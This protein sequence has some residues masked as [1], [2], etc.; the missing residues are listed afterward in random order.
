MNSRPDR[1]TPSV[2]IASLVAV[3]AR[4][5]RRLIIIGGV[6][7]L[8]LVVGVVW[9]VRSRA[10]TTV[11][12]PVQTVEVT[13]GAIAALLSTSGSASAA[14]Q[15][16]LTFNAS[17]STTV[18]GV[19]A[20]VDVKVGDRVTQGQ[21]L[22]TLDSRN[23]QRTLQQ[24][25]ARL[26]SER[27][28]LDQQALTL[29]Q[30]VAA[31]AQT[32]ASTQAALQ[33]ALNDLATLQKSPTYT[34]DLATARQAVLT[35]QNTLS[36]AQQALDVLVGRSEVAAQIDAIERRIATLNAQR[37]A[38]E[39]ELEAAAATNLAGLVAALTPISP[40]GADVAT[41]AKA[42][43]DVAPTAEVR[44]TEFRELQA[45][46]TLPGLQTRVNGLSQS[47]LAGIPSSDA[48][49]SA[50][51]AREAAAAGLAA[52]QARLDTVVNGATATNVQ[53]AQN[54][55]ASAR[56][57]AD[58]ALAKQSALGGQQNSNYALQQQQAQDAVDD[59]TLKAPFAGL[60]GAVSIN[61]GDL[62]APST[63]AITLTDPDRISVQL[64]VSEADLPGLASGQFGTATF[65]ALPGRTFIVRT[66]GVS[67]I[68]TVTSGVVTYQAQA[69]ILT[70]DTLRKEATALLPML[71]VRG[72][73]PANATVDDASKF[74]ES[75][76]TQTLPAPG[77]NANVSI[78]EQIVQD[79]LI[80]PSGVVRKRGTDTVVTIL[81]AAGT[82]EQVKVTAG[83]SDG[84]NVAITS[85][86]KAGDRAVVSGG[87][88]TATAQS[89]G[90][91]GAPPAGR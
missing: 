80:L 81:K 64:T 57:A 62:V 46:A 77:M 14:L 50:R 49:T 56:A 51:N 88:A 55:V 37:S 2:D 58:T 87:T 59:G 5:P 74:L 35:A 3:E 54:T 79:A 72:I 16:K 30:D 42:F 53:D 90:L 69:E 26:A 22:A 45:V 61:P 48:L 91:F 75:I 4:R 27:I 70:R 63:A 17:G 23:V 83:V 29:P 39:R 6:I 85:G 86:L 33:K 21:R 89:G 40:G 67:N 47:L 71:R 41:A 52:A 18:T 8:L 73:L 11:A 13:R 19:V 84:V 82:Q 78:M 12:T 20:S 65:D 25:N 9:W 15:T 60:V 76:A 7:L 31:A 43:Q 32:V 34:Q 1:P 38:A 24:A 44:D 68:P 10:T 66:S 28:K 36:T